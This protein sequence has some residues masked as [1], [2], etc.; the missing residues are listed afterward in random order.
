MPHDIGLGPDYLQKHDIEV[1][2]DHV[3]LAA[4]DDPMLTASLNHHFPAV[5]QFRAP[6]AVYRETAPLKR[7]QSPLFD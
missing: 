5:G 4:V 3:R 6:F 7:P 2:A 1:V